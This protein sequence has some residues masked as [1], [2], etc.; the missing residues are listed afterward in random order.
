MPSMAQCDVM[1]NVFFFGVITPHISTINGRRN[2]TIYIVFRYM[3][4]MNERTNE[5]NQD[6]ISSHI[7]CRDYYTQQ[8]HG[9][10]KIVLCSK[11]I[12]NNSV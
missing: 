9:V 11:I 10:N 4:L 1:C 7:E 8:N 5:S 2:Y 6:C 12:N 3:P